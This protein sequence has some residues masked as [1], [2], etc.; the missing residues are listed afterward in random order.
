[1]PKF[2]PFAPVRYAVPP[3]TDVSS[4]IAPPYDVLDEGP[5]QALLTK[6]EHNIVAIDL[7]VTP[8]KTVGPDEVYAAAG[9]MYRQ[10]LAEGVLTRDEQPSV[11]AY[12]QVYDLE[13]QTVQRRGMF[14]VLGVEAFNR[15]G[16]GIFRHEMTIAG[17]IGDRTKLMDATK[18]QL[19]PIF[20][21]YSDAEANAAGV[22]AD[23]YEAEPH[24]HGTTENDGVAHRCWWVT[25]PE[26]LEALEAFF[27][28]TDVFIA[29]GH[30]RYTTTLD[31][32]KAHPELPGAD[33][34]LFVLV[35][36][37][38][39]GMI[40]LPTHRVIT[41]MSGY[42]SSAVIDAIKSGTLLEICEVAQGSND[43]VSAGLEALAQQP[44]DR[45]AFAIYDPSSDQVFL[46]SATTPDPLATTHGDRPEVWRTLD[47]AILQHLIVEQLLQ[48]AFGGE[49]QLT[50]KYTADADEARRL[51]QAGT[52]GERI[53][54]L[55]R[56]TP[57]ESVMA[58][59]RADDV[60]PP[61]STYFFPKLA[62]GLVVNPLD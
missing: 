55:M 62:T 1:M 57:L 4:R 5:K 48:P 29:D 12:E 59:S 31:F 34:C 23:V 6:D 52:E 61:K 50:Y 58:V 44:D 7:P 2:K 10:W 43:R 16:G 3:G 15:P 38:D 18:A 8:P 22:L 45:A 40:V 26:K 33:G 30:H 13:G 32:S 17:G 46:V 20:G 42:S 49:Q 56:P 51:A 60:M 21:I 39:P 35:A 19:S 25:D 41:G 54:V 14:A 37:E 36:A 24:F 27:G 53:A 11:L 9:A 28:G 47:V